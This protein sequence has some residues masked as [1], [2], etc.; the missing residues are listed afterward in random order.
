M[1]AFPPNCGVWYLGASNMMKTIARGAVVLACALVA[2]ADVVV[3]QNIVLKYGWNAVYV[4]VAPTQSPDEVF[5]DWPVKSVGFYDP[6]TFLATRQFAQTWDSHGLS[7]NAVAMWH[8]D[9][10]EASQVQ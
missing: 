2:H 9:Y 5:A 10:P 3:R 4:E 8:R 7:L 6:A 1:Y